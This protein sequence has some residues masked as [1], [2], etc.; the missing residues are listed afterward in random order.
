[1]GVR[2]WSQFSSSQE[3]RHRHRSSGRRAT[4]LLGHS[5]KPL[6]ERR[7]GIGHNRFEHRARSAGRLQ[8]SADRAAAA[9]SDR[10]DELPPTGVNVADD[11]TPRR[12]RTFGCARSHRSLDTGKQK[13]MRR[14]KTPQTR[15][16]QSNARESATRRLQRRDSQEGNAKARPDLPPRASAPEGRQRA[17]GTQSTP[18]TPATLGAVPPDLEKLPAIRAKAFRAAKILDRQT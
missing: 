16:P 9:A 6:C 1:V 15:P 3:R 18:Q 7:I 14:G 10:D 2:P 5:S 12:F 4:R 13:P 8:Q 17:R 11:A